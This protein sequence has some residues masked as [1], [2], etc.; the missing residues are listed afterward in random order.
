MLNFLI[1]QLMQWSAPFF[2]PPPCGE[3]TGVG[4]PQTQNPVG[5]PPTP[6]LP[7]KGGGRKKPC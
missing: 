2:S 7:R 1:L 5:V 3:G 4:V 6:T